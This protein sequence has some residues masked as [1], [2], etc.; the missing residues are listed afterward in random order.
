MANGKILLDIVT[1]EKKLMSAE[2]DEITAPGFYGEFGVLSNHTTYL[3]Q[4]GIG[5]LSY[6]MNSAS[7]FVSLI[8]GYAEVGFNKVTILAEVAERAEDV[9][10]ERAEGALDRAKNRMSADDKFSDDDY[11]FDFERAELAL[12]RAT[13][14]ISVARES[15]LH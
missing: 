8:Q 12:K 7:Y 10:I 5:I 11:V 14:R 4:L 6:R 1:P 2:V 9:D 3:C 15:G 13:T